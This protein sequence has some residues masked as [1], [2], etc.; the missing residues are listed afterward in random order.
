MNNAV[1]IINPN[2]A[3]GEYHSF[4]ENLHAEVENAS[5]LISKSKQHTE[6]FI[7]ENWDNYDIFVAVGG[8][9]TISSIAQSLVFS[10]KIL[11]VYPMGSGNGFARENNFNKDLRQLLSKIKKSQYKSIDTVQI[12]DFFS[13]NVAGVGL[14]SAVAHSFEKTKRGFFNY[15]KTTIRTFFKFRNIQVN[16]KDSSLNNFAGKYLMMCVA[17]TR[18]FG[19]NAYIAPQAKIDDGKIDIALVKRFPLYHAPIFAYR[20]FGKKL[21]KDPYVSY[22]STRNTELEVDFRTWHIDGDAVQMPIRVPIRVSEKSLN[23]LI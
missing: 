4:L 2:S 22:I 3:H 7:K 19:N 15:I 23:I 14:D 6:D 13:I 21:E 17:N 16:F 20:L 5:I 12:A 9:G 10:D 11:A 18:Q 1:F 8:D